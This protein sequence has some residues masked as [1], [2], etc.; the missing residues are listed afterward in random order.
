MIRSAQILFLLAL[1]TLIT[2]GSSVKSSVLA[3]H[4][5]DTVVAARE[6]DGSAPRSA[7]A[8]SDR[9]TNDELADGNVSSDIHFHRDFFSF[10]PTT[11]GLHPAHTFVEPPL[12]RPE[13][14]SPPPNA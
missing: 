14:F 1:V 7:D 3:R 11:Q 13:P 9:E 4:I 12:Y 5:V 2:G 10:R 8:D 6:D